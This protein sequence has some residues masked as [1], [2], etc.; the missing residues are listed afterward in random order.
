MLSRHVLEPRAG[1]RMW[2]WLVEAIL[3]RRGGME[4]KARESDGEGQKEASL[5]HLLT[6]QSPRFHAASSR[7]W[8]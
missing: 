2:M 3:G 7:K 6:E 4:Q 5:K 8:C 1:L